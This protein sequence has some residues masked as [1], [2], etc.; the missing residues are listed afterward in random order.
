MANLGVQNNN[1]GNIKDPATGKFRVFTTPQEGQKALMDDLSLKISGGS[2]HIKPTDSLAKLASVWAPASDNNDP[3]NYAH[4]LATKLGVDPNTP[5]SALKDRIPDLASA[6]STAE[7]TTS[8]QHAPVGENLAYGSLSDQGALAQKI[9]A[10][11]PQYADIPDAELEQKILAKYPQYADLSS[12]PQS[13]SGGY[14]TTK[15][16]IPANVSTQTNA[17]DVTASG[18][19]IGDVGKTLGDVGTGFGNAVQQGISGQINPLS[20]GIQGLGALAGG[21]TGLVGN[22]L[23]H[24]PVV[25][26]LVKGAEGLLGNVA[27]AAANT[28]V[29]QKVVQGVQGFTQAHPELAGDIGGAANIAALVGGGFGGVAG[30]GL[31]EKGI[32]NAAEKGVLG[33]GVKGL[34]EKSA[35]KTAEKILETSPTISDVKSAVRSGRVSTEGG[36]AKVAADPLKAASIK[37][38]TPMVKEG[39]LKAGKPIDNALAIKSAADQT[40]IEMRDALRGQEV[41][42]IL[43]PE[44]LQ[45]MAQK[46]IQKAG[47]GL[48]TGE[49]PAKSLLDVF[50]KA[51]PQ[52]GDITAE[53]VLN[54]RQAVSRFV[55]D[56]KGDWSQLGVMTGFKTARDAIWDESRTLLADM[57]P[58]VPVRQMLERQTNLY[59]ALD[60]LPSAIK[61]ELSTEKK[62]IIMRYLARHPI[63]GYVA[64]GLAKGALIG[65]G[66]APVA[67]LIEGL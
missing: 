39:L 30:K 4:T 67:H 65:L 19:F 38:I 58:N 37:E 36:L 59:R 12:A 51:L 34:V 23:E 7:G 27:G 66:A 35:T 40:A 22:T 3:V 9:K 26:G 10:K 44:Q 31:V 24:L 48:P 25:G 43:Q 14:P 53:N 29:G 11:Y 2:T 61:K 41:Q 8:L 13:G 50:Y 62:N 16:E 56:N 57:A 46:V 15:L 52:S 45:G 42:N 49:N 20:A 1:P 5:I 55:L 17:G 21:V 18:S 47:E 54:A 33:S 32:Y 60:Y 63:Q 28:S 6:I 64:K